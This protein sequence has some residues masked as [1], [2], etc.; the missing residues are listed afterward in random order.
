MV[1]TLSASGGKLL[2]KASKCRIKHRHAS[3]L[4]LY[5]RRTI[6]KDIK[7]YGVEAPRVLYHYTLY[8]CADYL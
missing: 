5:T 1:R 3:K 2:L 6:V 7:W 8:V 4:F